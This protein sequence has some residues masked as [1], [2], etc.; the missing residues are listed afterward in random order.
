MQPPLAPKHPFPIATPIGQLPPDDYA[1]L[2]QANWQEMFKDTTLLDPAIRAYLEAENA[3]TDDQLTRPQQA[4][5]AQLVAEMKARTQICY[6][7]APITDGTY[8]YF[9][10]YSAQEYPVFLRLNADGAEQTLLDVNAELATNGR[11]VFL[12]G[13]DHSPDHRLLA[14]SVDYS[15][16]E[17]GDIIVKDLATGAMI[18]GLVAHGDNVVWH[19]D[20]KQFYYTK[21]SEAADEF[22]RDR[23][24]CHRI[25]APQDQDAL[26]FRNDDPAYFLSID[27]TSDRRFLLIELGNSTAAETH[28][29]DL[30]APDA[31]LVCLASRSD[32]ILYDVDHAH[33]QFY[34][35]TN[36]DDAV[37]FKIMVATSARPQRQHWVELIPH[38]PGR[39]I[40][41][42]KT[43]TGHLVYAAYDN[44]LP[45]IFVRALADDTTHELEFTEAAYY[46]GFGDAAGFASP[47]LRLT[48]SSPRQPT[49]FF[50]YDMATKQRILRRQ[51]TIPQHNPNDYIVER[52]FIP[53]Y[54]GAQVPL[55]I[56][57]HRDTPLD[58]SAPLWLYGYGS[59]GSILPVNFGSYNQSRYPLLNR[60]FII[61][62]AH[63]RGGADLGRQWHLDGKLG[64]KK[65]FVSRFY[66]RRRMA[67]GATL[68]RCRPDRDRG[69]QRRRFA[70]GSGRQH[71]AAGVDWLRDRRC[72]VC[73]CDEHDA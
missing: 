50:D 47:L 37:E 66:R 2:K 42:L 31:T 20:G 6:D 25:G 14:I 56:T 40:R 58:G 30:T 27:A 23:V 11:K 52:V 61:V 22:R 1:W 64:A 46:A 63:I 34:I 28:I 38:Q 45:R 43:F 73:R 41:S 18:G 39:L 67:G 19:P 65:K 17:D 62:D 24:F 54:D 49:Q 3:Y 35:R 9:I 55:T 60:G 7:T 44:C 70:D 72:A 48:Y 21:M 26:I 51:E 16:S 8:R 32:N 10:R 12:S 13:V 69:P 71:G 68:H 5:I 36:A 29:F 15:G 53:S 59:Y 57:R 4:L 33:G